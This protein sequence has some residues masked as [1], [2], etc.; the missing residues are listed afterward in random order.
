LWTA[1]FA[2]TWLAARAVAA[3]KTRQLQPK[4]STDAGKGGLGAP[5]ERALRV[6]L[7]GLEVNRTRFALVVLRITG[8]DEMVAYYGDEATEYALEA[9]G[10]KGL[11]LL[12]PDA[13]IFVL[14]GGRVAFV[15]ATDGLMDAGPRDSRLADA[16]DPYDTET[17]AMALGRRTC[18][19]S[20]DHHRLE[21]VVGWASAP[22][23]GMTADDLM[24]AAES[25]AL[26][27]AAFRRVGNSAVAV[28]EVG[29]RRAAAG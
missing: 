25:G 29:R 8:F 3:R 21:C 26:S 13:Q 14:P 10:R 28:P 5:L 15:F 9:V 27:T 1:G 4:R 18:E 11:R 12:G 16:I 7:R 22:A 19:H 24:Y 2:A 20:V 6:R 17:I 23:D